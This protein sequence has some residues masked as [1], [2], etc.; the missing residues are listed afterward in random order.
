MRGAPDVGWGWW[1]PGWGCRSHGASRLRR[2]P[3]H[4]TQ[5]TKR[6]F[7]RHSSK[8]FRIL[9]PFCSGILLSEIGPKPTG[10]TVDQSQNQPLGWWIGNGHEPT[11]CATLSGRGDQFLDPILT[12]PQQKKDGHAQFPPKEG[13]Q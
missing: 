11:R 10:Q 1:V 5:N 6:R 9:Y 12:N 3:D 13:V 8:H 7:V 4:G 2:C